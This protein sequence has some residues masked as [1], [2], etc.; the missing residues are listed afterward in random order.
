MVELWQ[1]D[2]STKK[3]HLIC[4]FFCKSH[5]ACFGKH[6]PM[7]LRHL[8]HHLC[9]LFTLFIYPPLL[10]LQAPLL[11]LTF[12]PPFCHPI[13]PLR[14]FAPSVDYL[15]ATPHS[16]GIPS[17]VPSRLPCLQSR[18]PTLS[19]FSSLLQAMTYL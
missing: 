11:L 9:F 4:L 7:T 12:L 6:F 14:F 1:T 13:L 5:L 16:P 10:A 3:R 15:D 17:D 18:L 2:W 8:Q 19:L